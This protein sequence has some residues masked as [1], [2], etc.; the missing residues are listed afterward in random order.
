MFGRN[1]ILIRS[2]VV[3]FPPFSYNCGKNSK[4]EAEFIINKLRCHVQINS[5]AEPNFK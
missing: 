4:S 3:L 1:Q 5:V 2:K